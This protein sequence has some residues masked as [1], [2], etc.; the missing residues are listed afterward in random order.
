[1]VPPHHFIENKKKQIKANDKGNYTK[2]TKGK[3]KF[4]NLRKA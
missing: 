4:I 2:V 1:V 3:K